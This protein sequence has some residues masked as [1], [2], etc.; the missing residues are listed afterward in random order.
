MAARFWIGTS[1]WHY[2][3]WRGVFYPEDLPTSRW[4]AHYAAIEL[5]HT[6]MVIKKIVAQDRHS[7]GFPVSR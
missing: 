7:V 4:L 6:L 1:G 2:A 5:D 3:H